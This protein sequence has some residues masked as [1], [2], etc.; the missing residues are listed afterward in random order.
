M[1][2]VVCCSSLKVFISFSKVL[3]VLCR[4]LWLFVGVRSCFVTFLDV[5]TTVLESIA[6][7]FWHAAVSRWPFSHAAVVPRAPLRRSARQFRRS[8]VNSAGRLSVPQVAHHCSR[9]PLTAVGCL[10]LPQVA[11]HFRR[12]SVT[13]AGRPSLPQGS[14]WVGEWVFIENMPSYEQSLQQLHMDSQRMQHRLREQVQQLFFARVCLCFDAFSMIFH[15]CTSSAF[16]CIFNEG[17]YFERNS[18]LLFLFLLIF[19]AFALGCVW[20]AS[21]TFF[22]ALHF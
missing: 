13:A 16:W 7:P 10:L 6:M 5:F 12:S 18:F 20:F 8:P 3:M 14:R 22:P 9:S 19:R 21:F 11:R 15:L 2:F 1:C 4:S 17:F